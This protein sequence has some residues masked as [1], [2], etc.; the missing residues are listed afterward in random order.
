M[1]KRSAR[2]FFFFY[3][4]YL[5]TERD[6]R[7]MAEKWLLRHRLICPQPVAAGHRYKLIALTFI[8]PELSYGCIRQTE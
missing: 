7:V 5:L 3:L 2:I 4:F 1:N 8:Q 6:S